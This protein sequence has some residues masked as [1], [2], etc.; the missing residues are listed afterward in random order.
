[1]N[2]TKNVR[3]FLMFLHDKYQKQLNFFQL[4]ERQRNR[5]GLQFPRCHLC[6]LDSSGARRAGSGRGAL[7]KFETD[8]AAGDA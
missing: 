8:C 2:E 7:C 5:A 6:R 4:Q 3:I 1:M